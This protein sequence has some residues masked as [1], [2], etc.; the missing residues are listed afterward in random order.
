V[1]PS[2]EQDGYETPEHPLADHRAQDLLR[3]PG[4][5]DAGHVGDEPARP[6]VLDGLRRAAETARTAGVRLAFEPWT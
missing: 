3:A 5:L 6:L 1:H 2:A 4:G